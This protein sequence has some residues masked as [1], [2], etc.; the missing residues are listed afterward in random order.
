MNDDL[1]L[2]DNWTGAEGSNADGI[3][4]MVR[5]RQNL[6]DFIESGKYNSKLDI[7]WSYDIDEAAE[8][9]TPGED[10]VMENFE[11]DLLEAYEADYQGILVAVIT[12]KGKKRWTWYVSDAELAKERLEQVL[13]RFETLPIEVSQTADPEWKGYYNFI[14]DFGGAA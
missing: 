3:P 6:Q 9:P 1:K 4:V 12:G 5:Y 10:G 14:A 2:E 11:A 13:L 8:M 7:T